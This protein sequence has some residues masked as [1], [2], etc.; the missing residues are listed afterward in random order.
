[1]LD[2]FSKNYGFPRERWWRIPHSE[3][4]KADERGVEANVATQAVAFSDG[5][6]TRPKSDSLENKFKNVSLK[7]K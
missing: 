4:A 7:L 2:K 1:M 6:G 3:E 5:K